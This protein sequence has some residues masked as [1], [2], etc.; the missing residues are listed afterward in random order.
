MISRRSWHL[1]IRNPAH[2]F[3]DDTPTIQLGTGKIAWDGLYAD[4][5]AA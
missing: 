3:K 5:P 1:E 4:A 2:N